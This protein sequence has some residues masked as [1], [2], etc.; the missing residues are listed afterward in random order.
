M[1]HFYLIAISK[2]PIQPLVYSFS[3]KLK[4]GVRVWV[5]IR[6]SK[7]IG[8]VLRE[9]EKPHFQTR[10]IL[11]VV[12]EVPLLDGKMLQLAIEM[13]KRYF[14][15]VGEILDLSFLPSHKDVK[16]KK[17]TEIKNRYLILSASVSK[18]LS[19]H[20]GKREEEIVEYLLENDS[21]EYTYALKK[22][23][24]SS[25]KALERKGFVRVVEMAP[26]FHPKKLTLN[27]E[28]KI[29][30]KE[31][32]SSPRKP[33]LLY[34][35]TGSG[36]TEVYFEVAEKVL[37]ESRKVMILVP[38]IS[39]TPQLLLRI[40]QRFPN[41]KIGVYHSAL[42]AARK[43]EWLRAVH[44]EIDILLGTRSAVWVP[45]KNLGLIIVDEEQDESYKQYAMRP[46]YNAVDVAKRRCELEKAALILSSA[47]PRVETYYDAKEGKIALHRLS[48]RAVGKLPA[49]RI[50][51]MRGRRTEIIS[52]ELISEMEKVAKNGN[53]SFLFVPRKGFSPRVQCANCGYIFTCPNCDVALTYHKNTFTLKCHYC[54]FSEKV[55]D[56]CPKCGS[57]NLIKGGIGTERVENEVSKIF[58]GLR[59][60]RIDK[61][62]I[63]DVSSLE[64]VL[65]EISEMKVD[66]VVGTKMI[67]KGL[68]FPRVELVG[69]IDTDHVFAIP[70]FRANERAFQL[71]AQMAGR[72]GRGVEGR[73]IIQS[74]EPDNSVFKAITNGN[75]EGFYEEELKRRKMLGYPPFKEL[76][77]LT[78]QDKEANRSK[79]F[80]FQTK[81][82]LKGGPFETLGPVESPVF[83]LKNVYR[84]QLL[85]KC[86]KLE[87]AL[88][89][90][91]KRLTKENLKFDPSISLKVDVQPYSTF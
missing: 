56:E 15:S 87:D 59:V 3:E 12:D 39:L 60:K 64:E 11:Q 83:K 41:K 84:Y 42:G 44:G 58:P 70:D 24:R 46:F 68:D 16:S 90:L 28:Q 19:S 25:I 26:S 81:N 40:R 89:F 29:V 86:E 54:G 36:K 4:S 78:I 61:D 53:Q 49:I 9:V 91:R 48:S 32:L 71:I 76:I 1:T 37:I 45:I 77:L 65:K 38:E 52:Q 69:V 6:N 13:A 74:M 79:A 82:V 21:V 23:P 80:A 50:V 20:L 14:S 7:K 62:E 31:I 2:Y 8:Y 72:A 27:S 55:P 88:D 43:K 34:G 33:H 10:N 30:V 67:T 47:T 66:I 73:V 63:N 18:I 17:I 75:I 35:I 51:D 5:P 57:K 85:L 22:F